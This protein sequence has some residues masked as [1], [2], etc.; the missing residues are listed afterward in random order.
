MAGID[1]DRQVFASAPEPP[2][3]RV[4][5][6]ALGPALFVLA[7][8]GVGLIGFKIYTSSFRP[9]SAGP[10][11]EEIAQLRQQV[12]DLQK[13]LDR[14]EKLRK[15]AQADFAP[16]SQRIPVVAQKPAPPKVAYRIT[17]ASKLPA[18]SNSASSVPPASTNSNNAAV[19]SELLANHE[20][21]QATADRL[22]D[23]VGAVGAQQGQI[24]ANQEALNQLLAQ[25]HRR[26]VAFE[27]ARSSSHIPVGPL[28]LQLKSADVKTQRYS[29]CVYIQDKC[30]ELKDRALNEV[31][32]FRVAKDAAP[33]ELVATKI[34]RDQ[35]LGFVEVPADSTFSSTSDR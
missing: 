4:P 35:I 24:A 19:Q 33:L 20:A 26:A 2:S 22:A 28:A 5:L 31:V 15:S 13:R 27:L 18:I 21:W 29:M 16:N 23:V 14:A 9:S 12:D 34:M 11:S 3:R 32:V 17:S 25:S 6:Q 10:A 1:F 30:I 8:G 7:L